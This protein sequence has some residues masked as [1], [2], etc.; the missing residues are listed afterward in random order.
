MVWVS[1]EYT[2]IGQ[3]SKLYFLANSYDAEVERAL[4]DHSWETPDRTAARLT[5]YLINRE[6][7]AR[8]HL[9]FTWA[10]GRVR[11]GTLSLALMLERGPY[12]I[13]VHLPWSNE[14]PDGI[15]RRAAE[16]LEQPPDTWP[17]VDWYPL[18]PGLQF[19]PFDGPGWRKP[20]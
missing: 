1:S 18:S 12:Q 6:P 5:A 15:A 11:P 3:P 10:S 8:N 16:L 20:S 7:L 9:S 17:Q 14:T 4:M 2:D 19:P 13:L